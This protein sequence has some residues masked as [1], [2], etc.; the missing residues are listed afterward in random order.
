MAAPLRKSRRL[1][2]RCIPKS[3]SLDAIALWHL[4]L[5]YRRYRPAFVSAFQPAI[6]PEEIRLRELM[7]FYLK[8]IAVSPLKTGE[9]AAICAAGTVPDFSKSTAFFTAISGRVSA[10]L[11]RGSND[12]RIST[13]PSHLHFQPPCHREDCRPPSGNEGKHAKF[14]NSA[15]SAPANAAF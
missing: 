1:I 15:H 5:A 2:R 11:I 9:D 7:W 4:S 14:R 3:R 8:Y 13:S 10:L 6:F 12:N